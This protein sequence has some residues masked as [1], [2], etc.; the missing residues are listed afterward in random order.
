MTAATGE[1]DSRPS[2]TH[3]ATHVFFGVGRGIASTVYGTIVVMA[4][5]TAAYATEK[6]PWKLAAIVASTAAVL[7]LAHIYAHGLSET[8]AHGAGLTRRTVVSIAR[9]ELG[10]L[11]AATAPTLALIL[12]AAGVLAESSAVWLALG[13]GLVTLGVEG[14]RYARVRGSGAP[15]RSWRPG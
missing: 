6:D 15:A 13:I 3:A 11:L 7:W 12:G 14:V 10:I 4:T 8:I 1:P 2:L 9:T 5:L